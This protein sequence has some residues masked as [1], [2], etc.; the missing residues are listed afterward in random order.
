[1]ARFRGQESSA[2]RLFSL[3]YRNS[4]GEG[5]STK[6][7][8]PKHFWLFLTEGV[9]FEPTRAFARQFSRLVH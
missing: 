7:D 3:N 4:K 9:G 6:H 1:M 5:A 8:R 2:Y